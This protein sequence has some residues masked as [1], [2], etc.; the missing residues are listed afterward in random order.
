MGLRMDPIAARSALA[1]ALAA[2][3][4]FP[5]GPDPNTFGTP[6][7]TRV[8]AEQ[9]RDDYNDRSTI[10]VHTSDGW[11]MFVTG[12]GRSLV[13]RSKATYPAAPW[14]SDPKW[15]WPNDVVVT[16]KGSRVRYVAGSGMLGFSTSWQSITLIASATR[17]LSTMSGDPVDV[18]IPGADWASSYVSGDNYI[19]LVHTGGEELQR[20]DGSVWVTEVPERIIDADILPDRPSAMPSRKWIRVGEM[21]STIEPRVFTGRPVGYSADFDIELQIGSGPA[22]TSPDEADFLAYDTMGKVLDVIGTIPALP[23]TGRLVP[24]GHVTL[25][26]WAESDTHE[27]I[28]G[29]TV[30]VVSR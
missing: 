16:Y 13:I 26:S 27:T 7:G 19:K 18:T 12:V 5:L 1:D 10:G 23:N 21:S 20:W 8:A 2:V 22:H 25:E 3:E 4:V 9:A 14:G 15:K 29:L 24:T 17:A 6:T 28:L 30:R 11:V